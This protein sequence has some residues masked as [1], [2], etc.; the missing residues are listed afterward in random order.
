MYGRLEYRAVNLA[1]GAA[2]Q[3]A[4]SDLRPTTGLRQFHTFYNAALSSRIAGIRIVKAAPDCAWTLSGA[5]R[6]EK[7]GGEIAADKLQCDVHPAGMCKFL[8]V[9]M[10]SDAVIVLKRNV[11]F[12]ISF[13]ISLTDH[14]Y[15]VL[16]CSDMSAVLT[17][18]AGAALEKKTNRSS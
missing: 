5:N 9:C 18:R 12:Y 2:F 14:K 16:S 11:F 8:L 1:T 3:C 6:P 7:A 10:F 17:A 13:E 4:R 15:P